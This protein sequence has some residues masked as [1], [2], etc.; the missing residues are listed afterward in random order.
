MP[1]KSDHKRAPPLIS[2]AVIAVTPLLI[3]LP[4]SATPADVAG[5]GEV[6]NGLIAFSRHSGGVFTLS[7]SGGRPQ[8][9]AVGGS[10]AWRADG[11]RLAVNR[12]VGINDDE[13]I[14]T[15]DPTGAHVRRVPVIPTNAHL[16]FHP[17]WA[18][19]GHRIAITRCGGEVECPSGYAITI[20][21]VKDGVP[22]LA[23]PYDN[24]F[25]A[26]PA[27]SPDGTAIAFERCCYY[28][29]DGGLGSTELFLWTLQDNEVTRLTN[30]RHNDG[31]PSWSPDGSTVVFQH[32]GDDSGNV[33]FGGWTHDNALGS[34]RVLDFA[35]GDVG[36]LTTGAD[37]FD[38]AYSPDGER[39]AFGRCP[40]PEAEDSCDL[41]TMNADGTELLRLTQSRRTERDP[42]WQ[43][44]PGY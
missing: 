4:A 36:R 26:A 17:T 1:M 43:P 25:D 13:V 19:G 33:P 37:D 18:P 35:T 27:W 2:L 3:V 24:K 38:P 14:E 7:E 12:S 23:Q 29:P 39:I 21:R 41:Y 34:I 9:I 10:P 32:G 40:A 42:T 11:D 31:A 22:V 5:S 6:A 28:N 15:M 44:I 30:N 8:K 16:N 20:I